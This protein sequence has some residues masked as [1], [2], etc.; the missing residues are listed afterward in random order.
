MYG[1]CLTDA[2]QVESREPPGRYICVCRDDGTEGT[3]DAVACIRSAVERFG[4]V[5]CFEVNPCAHPVVQCCPTV[6][7]IRQPAG[8]R[9]FGYE[10]VLRICGIRIRNPV[11]RRRIIHF[12]GS[13]GR[14]QCDIR[15]HIAD[16]VGDV[17]KNLIEPCG[18]FEG[19]CHVCMPEP[20][21]ESCWG[22]RF[23]NAIPARISDQHRDLCDAAPC[24][25]CSIR[26][27]RIRRRQ[28]ERERAE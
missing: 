28:F 16:C 13:C 11:V 3:V 15:R 10:C 17:G 21:L 4:T 14:R 19:E 24:D 5:W 6:V 12:N 20:I 8:H 25:T 2:V 9:L 23:D 7:D 1:E 18:V 27:D 22:W 26:Q